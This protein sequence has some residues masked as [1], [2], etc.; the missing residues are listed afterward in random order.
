MT[1][2][3]TVVDQEGK[4]PSATFSHVSTN[5]TIAQVLLNYN[6]VALTKIQT[7]EFNGYL[8][9][10]EANLSDFHLGPEA[11][12]SAYTQVPKKDGRKTIS[13]FSDPDSLSPAVIEA[14]DKFGH[15][16]SQQYLGILRGLKGGAESLRTLTQK[17]ALAL[18]MKLGH[19]RV[20]MAAACQPKTSTNEGSVLKKQKK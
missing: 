3:F 9:N 18:G 17:D 4:S 20:I 5:Q 8:L 13:G 7:I 10:A 12:L 19:Y 16:I 1:L 14:L 11:V 2:Y 6:S 15:E